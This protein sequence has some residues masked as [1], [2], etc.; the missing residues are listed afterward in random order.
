MDQDKK[1][2]GG[3]VLNV[4]S[5]GN[6]FINSQTNN[7]Y[8]TVYQGG[9]CQKEEGFTD[10]QIKIALLACVG[11]GKVINNKWK[12]AGAYWY[13]RW[14]C[15]YPVD[16]KEF[17]QKIAELDLDIEEKYNCEYR[18]IREIAT[19]SFMN[20]DATKMNKVQPSKNDEKAFA[21]CREI[22]LKLAEELGKAYLPKG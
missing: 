1:D 7:Y 17:C 11:E 20:Q 13:L 10:E 9:A 18:N 19:L 5:P 14:A 22:A 2:Q 15:K 8:G 21:I 4:Y 12:W 16:S 6:Q 3:I